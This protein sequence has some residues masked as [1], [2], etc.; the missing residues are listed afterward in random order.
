MTNSNTFPELPAAVR[1]LP[2]C[3]ST[4]L[5]ILCFVQAASA[6]DPKEDISRYIRD[7]WSSEQG[8]PGGA[9][10]AIAQS[11]GYL[12][13]GSAKGL[14]RFDGLNFSV[15]REENSLVLPEG[16]ILGLVADS[17][18]HLW[19]WPRSRSLVYYRDAKLQT[20]LPGL[21]HPETDVTAITR[22]KDGGILFS[23]LENGI[24]SYSH[25]KFVRL[26]PG[27]PLS[28][29]LVISLAESSDGTVWI[30]TRDSGLFML[31]A[32]RV[33]PVTPVLRDA[34]INCVLPV[35]DGKLWIGTDSGV[36]RWDGH[37]IVPMLSPPSLQHAQVLSMMQ[38]G[39]S[40]IWVGTS[41]GLLRFTA[42]G[43]VTSEHLGGEA[44]LALFEDREGNL[45]TGS[46]HGIERL[47]DTA[48]VTY[49][50]ANGLPSESNG[51]VYVDA[52]DRT[53]FA[54]LNGGLYWLDRD[55]V[56]TIS[57]AGL[58]KDVVYSLGGR[59]DE[60]W[61]GRQQGG[62]THLTPQ[63]GGVSVETFTHAQGLAQ[64]SVYSVYEARDGT[65]WAG[66][67]SGGVSSFR[68]GKFR[69]YTIDNG[70]ASNTVASILETSDGT[71]WFATANGL[72][73]L[74]DGRWLAYAIRDGLP[75]ENVNC[76]FEDSTG[77]LWIGTSEGLAF[78]GSGH[79]QIV[80][81]LES[82]LQDQILGIAEDRNG[83]LW[84]ATSNRVLRV[85]RDKLVRGSLAD[86]DVREYGLADGL[87][88]VEGVKR[89]RSVVADPFGHIWFSLNR[90]LS[91]VD[92]SRVAATSAPA[93]VHIQ[94]ILVD[95]RPIALGQ[96]IR[97]PANRQRIT[98]GYAGLS[99]AVPERVRFKYTLEGFDRGWS[100]PVSTRE[101]NYT[102]LGPGSY[103]FHVIASNPD[104]V[105]NSADAGIGFEIQPAFWQTWW[106]RVSVVLA[107]A[108][109]ILVLYR[110]RLRGLTRQLNVR[111]EE[112]LAERTRIA[113]ELHDTLLQGF[114][115]ASMQ[116]H[117]AVDRLPPDSAAKSPL[118]RVLQLMSQVIQEGRN[119]VQGLRSPETGS[120]NMEQAF[121]RIQ[122]ELGLQ[123]DI[124]FRVIVDGEPRPLHPVLR[125]EV[126]RIGRE[127]LVNAFR[128]SRASAI[129][130]E[131][132]YAVSRF[133]VLVRDNG[134][135]IDPE[136]LLSGR[137][138]HW[139]LPGMRERAERIGAKLRV[140]SRPSAGT[141]VELAV[142]SHVAFQSDSSRR[143]G[144]WISRL[145]S[146]NSRAA[147]PTSK[148]GNE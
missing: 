50:P 117:V 122:Q 67:L 34:K 118:G 31:H 59:K 63:N 87:R 26:A 30:G 5:A 139:G 20:F 29:F 70:L 83:N 38:D 78:F 106:F 22:G 90:G 93:V 96:T 4:G 82:L 57:E 100:Q 18:D 109:C 10:Y 148:N 108:L 147:S 99:L 35:N 91:V 46:E 28:T 103:R 126:Y 114:L 69:T 65:V 127:A 41:R 9:V 101:A 133:R 15:I 14:V 21:Q 136:L 23:S 130:M 27:T 80:E 77:V 60:L 143:F 13:I 104:G 98:V 105:W 37:K 145:Y 89:H 113:R 110:L 92:P 144:E 115:S 43:E 3:L 138:G 49:G 36:V 111:F 81:G 54:P 132:E 79:I 116:L 48:F 62:L 1:W 24:F 95:G 16:P 85:N 112:R 125:D 19:I 32:G 40:N 71:I 76:L 74:W 102:N 61:V 140:W 72:S 121:A 55:K 84:I 88:G 17:A 2:Q 25:G 51:P 86:G 33:S 129:E 39:E 141:E 131:L 47:R 146:R 107:C 134:C 45:W 94:S 64:N 120:L 56:G 8:Y 124:S 42:H 6:L 137:D 7:Q 123:D 66:T 119:A 12:W 75:S 128:H 11:D 58:N 135:G 44:V 52:R 73:A 97:I 68:N 53:W 142:P